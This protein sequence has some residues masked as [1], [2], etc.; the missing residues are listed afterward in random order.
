MNFALFGQGFR[1]SSAY[2]ERWF[3]LRQSRITST[4]TNS[5][6]SEYV[7]KEGGCRAREPAIDARACGVGTLACETTTHPDEA[8]LPER[9]NECAVGGR[10]DSLPHSLASSQSPADEQHA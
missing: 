1:S 4:S 10:Q 2:H 9:D 8:L 6:I 7:A 5:E 3:W